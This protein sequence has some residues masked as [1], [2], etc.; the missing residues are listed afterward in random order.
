MGDVPR[1]VSVEILGQLYPIRTPLDAHYVAELAAYVDGKI[2]T[3][4]DVSATTDTVRLAVL[5]ALNIADD[6][7]HARDSH[8][9]R[10]DDIMDRVARIEQLID[11][12][13]GGRS[14]A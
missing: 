13:L 1:V 2:R 4:A 11:E 9:E 6:Y 5:A 14:E 10:S 12:A 3:T 7:F 8:R